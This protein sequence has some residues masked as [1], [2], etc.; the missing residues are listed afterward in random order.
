MSQQ[1][2]FDFRVTQIDEQWDAEITRRVSARRTSVSK[3]KKGFA[4]EAL[5]TEWA[6]EALA[7]FLENQQQSNKRKSER[8]ATRNELAAQAVV[9]KEAA[10]ALYA[11]KQQAYFEALDEEELEEDEFYEE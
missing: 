11:E 1:N 9:A 10:A 5:A 2:K 4:T 3:R 7:G 8:R 6:K